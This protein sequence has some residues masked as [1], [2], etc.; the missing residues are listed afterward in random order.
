MH[1]GLQLVDWLLH[2]RRCCVARM[3]AA[4]SDPT[5]M[6]SVRIVAKHLDS[7]QAQWAGPAYQPHPDAKPYD[8]PQKLKG[9]MAARGFEV[10][11]K[12]HTHDC[13]CMRLF[14]PRYCPLPPAPLHMIDPAL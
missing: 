6:A 10:R 7:N 3:Q 13:S 11:H 4:G 12:G 1:M 5:S 9:V 2:L 14:Q 8:G